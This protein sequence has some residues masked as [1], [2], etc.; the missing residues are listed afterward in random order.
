MLWLLLA[1]ALRSGLI[2]YRPPMDSR[3]VPSSEAS[4]RLLT[5]THWNAH[6][7]WLDSHGTR[8]LMSRNSSGS[9]PVNSVVGS[10]A[11]QK[12]CVRGRVWDH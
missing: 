1:P 3:Q 10:D 2:A 8:R 4:S 5:V 6:S 7:D 12:A 11:L 9:K